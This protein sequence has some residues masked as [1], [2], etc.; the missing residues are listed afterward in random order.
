[1]RNL[2]K[3]LNEYNLEKQI[4]NKMH[5]SFLGLGYLGIKYD[6]TTNKFLNV[7]SSNINYEKKYDVFFAGSIS[8]SKK[9]RSDVISKL[10]KDKR[11]KYYKF[12]LRPFILG[13]NSVP[14]NE[15]EFYKKLN[16]IKKN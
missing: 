1:M 14:L 13:E 4:L 2:L 10:E 12:F 15:I 3:D 16:A 11:L 9:I 5:Q 7:P 8:K 6:I